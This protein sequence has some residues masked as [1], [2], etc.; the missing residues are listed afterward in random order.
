MSKVVFQVTPSLRRHLMRN[1]PDK[2]GFDSLTLDGVIGVI[3]EVVEI[4]VTVILLVEGLA[5]D[6]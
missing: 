3:R 2:G 1:N 4:L 5:K 6:R